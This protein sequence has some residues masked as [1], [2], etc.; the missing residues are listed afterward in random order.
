[1][2]EKPEE[3]KPEVKPYPILEEGPMMEDYNNPQLW[4]TPYS[5]K[6]SSKLYPEYQGE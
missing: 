2:E 3:K 5:K 6:T 1:M 4:K